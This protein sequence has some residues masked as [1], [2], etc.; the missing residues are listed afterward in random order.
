M[1]EFTAYGPFGPNGEAP[2]PE[3]D[4]KSWKTWLGQWI[5]AILLAAAAAFLAVQGL[6]LSAEWFG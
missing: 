3:E 1:S 5:L 2:E 4:Y 6:A